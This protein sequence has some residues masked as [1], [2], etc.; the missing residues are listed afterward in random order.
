[1][2]IMMMVVIIIGIMRGVEIKDKGRRMIGVVMGVVGL[3]AEDLTVIAIITIIMNA[4]VVTKQPTM[5]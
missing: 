3:V 1:M 4:K 5:I 2:A